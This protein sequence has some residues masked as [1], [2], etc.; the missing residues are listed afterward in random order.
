MRVVVRWLQRRYV[1]AAVNQARQ[2]AIA[3]DAN[4]ALFNAAGAHSPLPTPSPAAADSGYPLFAGSGHPTSE[5]FAVS[6]LG[7]VPFQMEFAS[8][9]RGLPPLT[10]MGSPLL[11]EFSFNGLSSF[12]PESLLSSLSP[13]GNTSSPPNPLVLPQE[14]ILP[15]IATSSAPS[16][17]STYDELPATKAST[18]LEINTAAAAAAHDA[19]T[20]SLGASTPVDDMANDDDD[21]DKASSTTHV[22][23][24]FESDTTE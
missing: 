20:N 6:K 8:T 4:I 17:T 3:A 9:N 21:D 23:N 22:D 2:R 5:P 1:E 12:S 24:T 11:P 14:P 13:T 16:M 18:A 7:G 10:I 19:D 15:D